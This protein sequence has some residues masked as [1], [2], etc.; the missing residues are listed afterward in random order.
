MV[1]LIVS[2][3]EFMFWSLLII[4]ILVVVLFIILYI[5]DKGDE[6]YGK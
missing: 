2:V 4:E 5:K 6:K 1:D 3:S